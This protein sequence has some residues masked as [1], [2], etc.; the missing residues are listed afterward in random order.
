MASSYSVRDSIDDA[1]RPYVETE[2]R[3]LIFTGQDKCHPFVTLAVIFHNHYRS[4]GRSSHYR[5]GVPVMEINNE[6]I[7]A[8]LYKYIPT[9]KVQPTADDVL[10]LAIAIAVQGL[11]ESLDFLLSTYPGI[12]MYGSPQFPDISPFIRPHIYTSHNT[13]Y[14]AALIGGVDIIRVLLK[15]GLDYN[16]QLSFPGWK[17][18]KMKTMFHAICSTCP[19]ALDLLD[20]PDTTQLDSDGYTGQY[21]LLYKDASKNYITRLYEHTHFDV[22]ARYDGLTLLETAIRDR[23]CVSANTICQLILCGADVR[24][25]NKSADDTILHCALSCGMTYKQ[26]EKSIA[27]QRAL[28][29]EPEPETQ[30]HYIYQRRLRLMIVL[31]KHPDIDINARNHFGETTLM[32]AVR[33][34]DCESVDILLARADIDKKARDIYGRTA[35]QKAQ[36]ALMTATDPAAIAAIQDMID[37]LAL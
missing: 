34:G 5:G 36:L 14:E 6:K 31:L 21:Y 35:L 26:I 22:N 30:Q 37:K 8:A 32:V 28:G 29:F 27:R 16:K 13:I 1:F 2:Y 33:N 25:L 24:L 23:R 18:I 19:N 9:F 10:A 12:D 3:P 4:I 11:S 15:H 20:H 17:Q 7:L